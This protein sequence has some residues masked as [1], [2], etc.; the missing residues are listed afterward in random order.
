MQYAISW[1]GRVAGEPQIGLTFNQGMFDLS[2]FC[3][4]RGANKDEKAIAM[5]L[6]Y[7]MTVV[8]NQARAAEI[9]SYTGCSPDLEP[10]L[11]KDKLGE[12]PTTRA[13]KSV[14]W[15]QN[16][17]WWRDNGEMVNK[18]WEQFRLNL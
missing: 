7:E 1:S 18:K 2:Y 14:Q 6:L 4:P 13:N 11:P 8:Q 17:G 10:L 12:F 15:Q 3:V 5:K 16:A 9:V